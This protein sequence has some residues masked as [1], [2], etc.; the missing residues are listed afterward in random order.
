MNGWTSGRPQ[1][2]YVPAAVREITPFS[3]C[4]SP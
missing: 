4:A 1:A 3:E 2:I